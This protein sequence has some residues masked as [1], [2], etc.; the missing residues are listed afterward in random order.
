MSF[1][2]RPVI[3][4]DLSLTGAAITLLMPS[5]PAL[6]QRWSTVPEGNSPA[7]RNAR[8]RRI[9]EPIAELCR[10]KNPCFAIVEGY[11]LGASMNQRGHFDRAELRSLLYDA[12]LPHCDQLLE[13]NPAS[14]KCFGADSGDADK[15]AMKAALETRYGRTFTKGPRGYDEADSFACAQLA[16]LCAGTVS[17]MTY[18]QERVRRLVLGLPPPPKPKKQK[19][20]PAAQGSLL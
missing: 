17:A 2:F 12:M 9:V 4:I 13:V 6:V 7:E 15:E 3:G 5:A 14:L 18:H 16:L 10:Q 8:C 11:A 20:A 1:D 19:S